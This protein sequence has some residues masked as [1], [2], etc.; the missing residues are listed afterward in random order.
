MDDLTWEAKVL[1]SI[2]RVEMELPDDIQIKFS[3]GT[4][5]TRMEG[6]DA[7]TLAC[8]EA[9]LEAALEELDERADEV[10]AALLNRTG[11]TPVWTRAENDSSS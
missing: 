6:P 11:P 5:S 8:V 9:A 7:A 1:E 4:E 3:W 2:L 10:A